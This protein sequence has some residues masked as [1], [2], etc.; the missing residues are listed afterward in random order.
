MSAVRELHRT[1]DSRL[2]SRQRED[3]LGGDVGTAAR[4]HDLWSGV[5]RIIDRAPSLADLRAHRL[6]LIAAR[7]WR[8]NGR[9]VPT[10]FVDDEMQSAIVRSLAWAALRQVRHAYDGQ[11]LV[12]KGLHTAAFY[13]APH[14]RPFE[15]LDILPDDPDKMHRALIAAGFKPTQFPDEYYEGLHHMRPLIA[16][17]ARGLAVEVHRWPN[18]FSWSD[19]PTREELLAEAIPD[20][21]DLPGIAGL[22]PAQHALILAAHSWAELPFRRLSDLVDVAAV[23]N[24]AD[25]SEVAAL[26]RAWG[27]SRVWATTSAAVDGLF[28]DGPTPVSLRVWGRN[29]ATARDRTVAETH[30]RRCLSSLWALSPVPALQ[31]SLRALIAAVLPA[32]SESWRGKLARSR[33][34]LRY[35]SESATDHAA[36][37]GAEGRRAP[38]F[39]RR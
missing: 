21:L 13:P 31:E 2:R 6:H 24:I 18:W 17:G 30:L 26:A 38:R 9:A 25:D 16:P 27:M 28:F 36:R 35:R 3:E 1:K 12:L 34:A 32:P 10:A 5:D 11:L 39:R 37:L 23:S 15:D 19:P 33:L 29:L 4:G 20:V 8:T 22:A 14:L 7:R